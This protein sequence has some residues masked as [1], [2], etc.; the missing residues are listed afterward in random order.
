MEEMVSYLEEA[1]V[2]GLP[3]LQDAVHPVGRLH[4]AVKI[5]RIRLQVFLL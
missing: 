2:N 1:S 3:Q 5:V 4:Q